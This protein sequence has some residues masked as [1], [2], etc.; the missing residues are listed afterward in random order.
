[1][2]KKS[3]VFIVLTHNGQTGKEAKREL[4][5]IVETVKSTKNWKYQRTVLV[6]Q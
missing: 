4:D 1:M 5:E 2:E 6:E 3:V